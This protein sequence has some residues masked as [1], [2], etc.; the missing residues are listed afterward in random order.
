MNLQISGIEYTKEKITF[1][2]MYVEEF[3]RITCMHPKGLSALRDC[4]KMEC[5][6]LFFLLWYVIIGLRI[7]RIRYIIVLI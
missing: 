7:D 3:Y 5:D 4:H 2:K 1:E 6:S